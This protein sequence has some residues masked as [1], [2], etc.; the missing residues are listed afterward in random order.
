MEDKL[1]IIKSIDNDATPQK[2]FTIIK[3]LAIL[4]SLNMANLLL[5]IE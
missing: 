2:I 4:I 5:I 3:L 1:I